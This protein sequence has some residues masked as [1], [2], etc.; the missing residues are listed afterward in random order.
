MLFRSG[1]IPNWLIA[2]VSL[3]LP[4]IGVVM[5]MVFKKEHKKKSKICIACAITGVALIYILQVIGWAISFIDYQEM[6]SM[7]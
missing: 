3:I 7:E 2:I 5:Y 1:N 4:P 6:W